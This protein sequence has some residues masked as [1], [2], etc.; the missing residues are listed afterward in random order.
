MDDPVRLLELAAVQLWQCAIL[1]AGLWI[2]LT[3][4]RSWRAA[5]RCRLAVSA[6]A[7]SL[8]LPLGA[9][10]PWPS[11]TLEPLL[12]AP[13]AH[14]TV[15]WGEVVAKSSLG[16]SDDSAGFSETITMSLLV[17]W[18]LGALAFLVRMVG[19][20]REMSRIA[21]AAIIAPELAVEGLTVARNPTVSSPMVVR[22]FRP[23]I[24]LP[25]DYGADGSADQLRTI[26]AHEMAHV[27]RYDPIVGLLQRVAAAV[28]W[29]NPALH[30]INNRIDEEREKACDEI[31]ASVAGDPVL[32]AQALLGHARH[33]SDTRHPELALAIARRPS[34]LSRRIEH[35]LTYQSR[36]P[37]PAQTAAIVICTAAALFGLI[38][39]TP[40]LTSDVS[41]A[42]PKM[43]SRK[44]R[45]HG[46]R[47]SGQGESRQIVEMAAS[48]R[49]DT[50]T[51]A[52]NH[53]RRKTGLPA[54]AAHPGTTNAITMSTMSRPASEVSLSSQPV[55]PDS[56][57]PYRRFDT[58]TRQYRKFDAIAQQFAR[59]DRPA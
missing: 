11:V 22:I 19:N 33:L 14:S 56:A 15:D 55:R 7:A 24:I 29:W 43:E 12:T 2:I 26:L 3:S 59:F 53:W 5:S 41:P 10:L 48:D 16:L 27:Q 47:I 44:D 28:F 39:A 38:A 54:G 1:A 31:A 35:V 32:F 46:I 58:L 51:A 23:M 8:L 49:M 42:A 52:P 20:I 13:L 4:T 50:E 18:G 36:K 34:L 9:L 25:V 17:L 37:A 57:D 45:L 30:W 40:R 6:L 21:D